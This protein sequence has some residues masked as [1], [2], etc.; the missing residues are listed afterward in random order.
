MCRLQCIVKMNQRFW[1]VSHVVFVSKQ[2]KDGVGIIRKIVLRGLNAIIDFR[3][4]LG[5]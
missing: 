2:T 4:L 3:H 1:P 5:S